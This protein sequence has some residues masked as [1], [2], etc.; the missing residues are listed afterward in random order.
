VT[1][2]VDAAHDS[3]ALLVLQG[4]VHEPQK[5]G[6]VVVF[7]HATLAPP[8]GGQSVGTRGSVHDMPQV[9]P[10]HVERPPAG[11]GHVLHEVVPQEL[12]DVFIK[13]VVAAPTPQLCVPVGQTQFPPAQ[14]IP[15]VHTLPHVPQFF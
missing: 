10:L 12:V 8:P 6:L 5:L 13:H 9:V 11:M 14:T 3:T 15:P 7:T 2:Q 4:V 1:E